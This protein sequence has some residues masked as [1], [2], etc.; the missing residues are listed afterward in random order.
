MCLKILNLSK[1]ANVTSKRLQRDMQQ[2]SH[3]FFFL[4]TISYHKFKVR[5]SISY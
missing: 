4:I 1:A 2:K 5:E 3:S